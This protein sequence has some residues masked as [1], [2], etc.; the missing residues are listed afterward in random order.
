ML[1]IYQLWLD[2]LYPRAK[3]ADGLAMI[4]KLGHSKRM[5]SMRKEWIKE[6]KAKRTEGIGDGLSTRPSHEGPLSESRRVSGSS[7][8]PERAQ[9][10]D[11]S[12]NV[13]ASMRQEGASPGTEGPADD[14]LFVSDGHE[15]AN[16]PSDDE[17]DDLD[18]ILA[19]EDSRQKQTKPVADSQGPPQG[20]SYADDEEAMAEMG[21]IW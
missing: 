20:Q 13:A 19:E 7:K 11:L 14:S 1:K 5:Q 18:A 17:L 8:K 9:S 4:E 3:F 2:D 10:P 12:A 16:A 6:G 15:D 21:D